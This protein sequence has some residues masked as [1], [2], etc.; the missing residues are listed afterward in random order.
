M[1][2]ENGNLF[3]DWYDRLDKAGYALDE[4]SS[5]A[6]K[7]AEA[8]GI[9]ADASMKAATSDEQEAA[10]AVREAAAI[11]PGGQNA[12]LYTLGNGG[13]VPENAANVSGEMLTGAVLG[14]A[15]RVTPKGKAGKWDK[16][17]QGGVGNK[18]GG[19]ISMGSMLAGSLGA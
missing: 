7:A 4:T 10:G 5:A 13:V 16:F 2:D 1:Y 17:T 14:S 19:A 11:G 6:F 8:D 3:D 12:M 9:E 15:K 18:L